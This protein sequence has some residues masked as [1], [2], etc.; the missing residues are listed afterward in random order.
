MSMPAYQVTLS[1]IALICD[2]DPGDLRCAEHIGMEP[3]FL[4]EDK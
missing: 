1:R 4:C 3:V 2:T